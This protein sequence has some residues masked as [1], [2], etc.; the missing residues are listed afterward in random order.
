MHNK[1]K[2]TMPP[3]SIVMNEL[4]NIGAN[5]KLYYSKNLFAR[6]I[7]RSRIKN[8]LSL[9]SPLNKV[10]LDVGCGTGFMAYNLSKNGARTIA[11]DLKIKLNKSNAVFNELLS[12]PKID[13]STADIFHL[14]FKPNS[15]DIIYALDM[16][17]H[18]ENVEIAL[19]EIKRVLKKEGFLIVS[20]PNENI[21]YRIGRKITGIKKANHAHDST[22]LMKLLNN[23]FREKNSISVTP[24]KLFY[25]NSYI[26]DGIEK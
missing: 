15:F 7:F 3:K 9:I 11:C 19:I 16:L 5:N 17:E 21:I 14:P 6:L 20:I 1:I 8:A 24:F 22:E 13:F 10:V 4:S 26:L 23:L 2:F 18:L 25:I 12:G